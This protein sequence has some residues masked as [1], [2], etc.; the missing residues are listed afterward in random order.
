MNEWIKGKL[1]NVLDRI[2]WKSSPLLKI[3]LIQMLSFKIQD[4]HLPNGAKGNNLSG[5]L[6]SNALD[7]QASVSIFHVE[8]QRTLRQCKRKNFL[9]NHQFGINQAYSYSKIFIEPLLSASVVLYWGITLAGMKKNGPYPRI[10][11]KYINCILF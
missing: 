1:M 3:L 6:G 7:I 8:I 10:R 5:K 11:R 4:D 2:K 9:K